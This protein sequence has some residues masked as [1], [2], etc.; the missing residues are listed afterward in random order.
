MF[1]AAVHVFSSI[2]MFIAIHIICTTGMDKKKIL[3]PSLAW[4]WISRRF[5]DELYRGIVVNCGGL[6][7]AQKIHLY[8]CK[9]SGKKLIVSRK[10]ASTH[11]NLCITTKVLTPR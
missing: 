9:P 10:S 6:G 1:E 2:G 11:K 4:L 5:P 7:A 3:T 8:S